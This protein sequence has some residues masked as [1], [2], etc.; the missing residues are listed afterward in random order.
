MS[1]DRYLSPKQVSKSY[2]P[3]SYVSQLFSFTDETDGT[4]DTT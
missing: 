4:H 1:E 3:R 2:R